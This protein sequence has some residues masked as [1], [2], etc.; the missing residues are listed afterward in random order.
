MYE[1]LY[2][3]TL[4]TD[5]QPLLPHL[6]LPKPTTFK[7]PSQITET[8]KAQHLKQYTPKTQQIKPKV[9]CPGVP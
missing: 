2:K 7:T 9:T 1:V 4:T 5:Q 3:S 6:I 8:N